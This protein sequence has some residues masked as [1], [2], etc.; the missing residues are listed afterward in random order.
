MHIEAMH[1]GGVGHA[2]DAKTL[3][4][5]RCASDA[6]ASTNPATKWTGVVKPASSECPDSIKR[7]RLSRGVSIA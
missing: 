6:I 4:H 2:E 7:R 1:F 3:G 5:I